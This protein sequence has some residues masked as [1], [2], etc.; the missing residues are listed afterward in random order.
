L[1]PRLLER[2]RRGF[3]LV[4]ALVALL[5]ITAALMLGYGF[6]MRQPQASAR[7]D[8]GSEALRALESSLETLRSGAIPLESGM[9]QPVL[10]YP[11]PTAAEDLLVDLDVET[12]EIENLF[13]VTLEARYRVGRA[14]HRRQVQSMIWSP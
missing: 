10:A 1:H 7:L 9:L 11:P 14:I 6:M 8:A 13:I 3:T 12:T 4:E 5:L 2:G